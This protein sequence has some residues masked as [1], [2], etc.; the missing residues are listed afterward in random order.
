MPLTLS[1]VLRLSFRGYGY[2]YAAIPVL[3][4][5]MWRSNIASCLECSIHCHAEYRFVYD[6]RNG[7]YECFC[8]QFLESSAA[9]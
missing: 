5:I 7:V 1:L 4:S 2:T 3:V 8:Y 6:V 9:V